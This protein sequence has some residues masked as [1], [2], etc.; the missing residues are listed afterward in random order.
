MKKIAVIIPGIGYYVDKPLLYYSGKLAASYGYE[1][2]TVPYQVSFEKKLSRE[3]R[4]KRS[5]DLAAEQCE[6]MLSQVDFS[7]CED[8]VFISKSLGTAVAANYVQEN[9]LS[10]RHI[11][12]TPLKR[13]F[14]YHIEKGIAFHGTADP[15]ADTDMI[16]EKCT[17]QDILLYV[18]EGANHSMETG[19]VFKDIAIMEQIMRRTG[20][21]FL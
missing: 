16:T 5:F 3:E 21:Y 10:A 7:G 19:T 14:E 12:Y 11:L 4:L 20:K 13:T 1:V 2:I 17:K 9:K 6:S 18:T 15:W 8:C